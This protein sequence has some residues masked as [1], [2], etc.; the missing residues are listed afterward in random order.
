MANPVVGSLIF[1]T[2]TPLDDTSWSQ[3]FTQ[4]VNWMAD[5]N[6]DFVINSATLSKWMKLTPLTTAQIGA[7]SNPT[8]GMIAYNSDVH[9]PSF[10]D[11]QAW[12]IL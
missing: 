9:R 2:D 4:V 5:G 11:G 8:E 7:I 3:N 12:Q 1:Y 6:A 10:Y